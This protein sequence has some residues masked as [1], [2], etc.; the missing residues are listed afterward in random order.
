MPRE[1][2]PVAAIQLAAILQTRVP[3]GSGLSRF[4]REEV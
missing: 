1:Y 2:E 3:N 4:V